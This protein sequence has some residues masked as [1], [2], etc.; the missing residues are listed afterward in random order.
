MTYPSHILRRVS[1]PGRYAGGEYGAVRKE[2]AGIESRVALVFPEVY[3]IAMSHL[4][5]QILYHVLN[6]DPATAAER[7]HCPWPDMEAELRAQGQPLLSL[8]SGRPLHSFDVVGVSVLYELTA[9]NIL[10]VLDVG[11]VPLRAEDRGPA[12]PLVIAGGPGVSNPEPLSLFFDLVALG[13]GEEVFPE[14][15]RRERELRREGVSKADRKA[16]LRRF[17]DLPGIY[18]PSLYACRAHNGRLVADEAAA[19]GAALPWPVRKRTVSDLD[20]YPLPPRPVVPH[21][22]IVHDR[23]TTEISRGCN[24]GCRFCHASFYYRPQRERS[25]RQVVE[26][27]KNVVTETGWDEV[28]LS[29]LSSGGYTCV[30]DLAEIL[31]EDLKRQSAGLSFPS[32][33]AGSLSRR[34]ARAVAE[35]RKSGFTLAPEAGSQ[36]LRD[37]VNKNL[38]EGEIMDA[39]LTARRHGWD[40]VKLYFMVGLPGETDEDIEAIV[41]LVR[42]I[43]A[44]A[45]RVKGPEVSRRPL[46]VNITVSPFVPKPHTPFQWAPME[47]PGE[48]MRKVKYLRGALRDPAIKLKWHDPD[49]SRLEALL[50]RGDR[51]MGEVVLAAWRGGARFEGWHETFRP[52]AWSE[53]LRGTGV[54]E[55]TFLAPCAVA[56]PLPWSHL[57]LGSGEDWLRG[58]WKAASESRTTPP[59]TGAAGEDGALRLE[60]RGCGAACDIG[61]IEQRSAENAAWLTRTA[62]ALSTAEGEEA[63]AA[64]DKGLGTPFRLSFSRRG[65]AAWMS[66]LDQ[67]RTLQRVLRRAGMPLRHTEGFTPRPVMGF[68]PALGVGVAA[69]CEYVDAFL[70]GDDPGPA[71]WLDRL[72]R[73]SMEGLVFRSLEYLPEGAP[74]IEAWANQAVYRFVFPALPEE[75]PEA[76]AGSL[77]DRVDRLLDQKELLVV[78]TRKGTTSTKNVRPFLKK[79]V[80]I[81]GEGPGCTMDVSVSLSTDG[82]LRPEEWVGL[83]L[84]DYRGPWE[85]TRLS[86]GR[87]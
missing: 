52:E 33:R 18:A 70:Q 54:D 55:G 38:S 34:L 44:E 19:H 31:S 23:A 29:S 13:D 35:C 85:V 87:G 59:C 67:V 78:R 68:S 45:S 4:G 65:P 39:V 72:N 7:V 43:R 30:E 73:V 27:A 86:L 82:T 53:A 63:P 42:K 20:A 60:C 64:R 84:P 12:H 5:T 61:A 81:P 51:R 3:E 71:A 48:V 25:A 69:E 32:L 16:W 80:C 9:T 11:G 46:N 8:E 36:R 21:V 22:E 75:V 28:S 57:E 47:S 40:L 50:S 49:V 17:L 77:P 83:L 2:D 58:E 66:H 6:A 62:D 26:W 24:Q 56:D 14:I 37:A 41:S 76:G 10:T 74:S 15:V 79:A 1:R